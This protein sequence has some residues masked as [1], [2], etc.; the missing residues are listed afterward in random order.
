M[1]AERLFG[2]YVQKVMNTRKNQ[3]H[4]QAAM[5]RSVLTLRGAFNVTASVEKDNNLGSNSPHYRYP[6]NVSL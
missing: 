4:E 2:G 1:A 3:I 5:K 6:I